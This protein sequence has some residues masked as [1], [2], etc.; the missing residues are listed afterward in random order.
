MNFQV[1]FP[2][3]VNMG[4]MKRFS[5]LAKVIGRLRREL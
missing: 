2:A 1:S 5:M 3:F 4:F